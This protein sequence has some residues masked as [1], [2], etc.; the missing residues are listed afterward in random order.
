MDLQ[1]P[2]TIVVVQI[3]KIGDMILTTPLLSGLKKLFPESNLKVLASEINKDIPLNHSSVN[4][5]IVYKKN[6]IK[7]L[8]LL[9]SSINRSDLWIDTK[10]NYSKT[11][12]LL[13]K[14]LKPEFSM[15]FNFE[16]KIFDILL[17]EFQKG[18]HAVDI[19]TSPLNYFNKIAEQTDTKPS[20]N[21]PFEIQKKFNLKQTSKLQEIIINIS[22]GNPSR[23]LEKEKW[24]DIIKMINSN[25]LSAFTLIGLVRDKEIISYL[26]EKCAEFNIKFIETENI[27]ETS[28]V[29]KQGDI[30]I[31]PDTAIVHIC[32]A[33]DKPVVALYPDVKWNLQKFAPLSK[34]NEAVVSKAEGSIKDI[35]AEEVVDAFMRIKKN[36]KKD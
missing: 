7:N 22:A 33:F 1:N 13:V 15:G 28:E 27:L 20:F 17:K 32:S 11:S 29:I 18:N 8:I 30:V 6:F 25:E 23:Y 31:T 10:D 12:E 35:T 5:V 24:L 34:Y 26:L 16:K 14:F 4:E 36:L 19:N 21:I 2:K 3:G 9:K